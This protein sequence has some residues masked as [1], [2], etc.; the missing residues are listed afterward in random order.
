MKT[1]NKVKEAMKRVIHN[2]TITMLS[3]A[4]LAAIVTFGRCLLFLGEGN[5]EG[6]VNE[7]SIKELRQYMK[8]IKG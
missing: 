5:M 7:E 3:V 1:T 6:D 8:E 2:S 4:S